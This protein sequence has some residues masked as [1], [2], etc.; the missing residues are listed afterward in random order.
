MSPP[1][2]GNSADT[3]HAFQHSP[4]NLHAKELRLFRLQ[5]TPTGSAQMQGEIQHFNMKEAPAFKALSYVWGPPS[6]LEILINGRTFSVRENLHAFLNEIRSTSVPDQE[7]WFWID[8][9]CIDQSNTLER[10][11][12]VG[13][14]ADIYSSAS[15]TI[16]WLGVSATH[17]AP[18]LVPA[19]NDS[20][21]LQASNSRKLLVSKHAF[22]QLLNCQYWFRTWIIQEFLLATEVNIYWGK[23]RLS[24]NELESLLSSENQVLQRHCQ[25]PSLRPKFEHISNLMNLRKSSDRK[26][27]RW[28]DVL[29]L[30]Q[31]TKCEDTRDRIYAVL[32][33]V[34][35]V[36]AIQ[37]DYFAPPQQ[38]LA[39]VTAANI[40]ADR[41][42]EPGVFCESF[43][44]ARAKVCSVLGLADKIALGPD[45]SRLLLDRFW[46]DQNEQ[47]SL[48][49][50]GQEVKKSMIQ[51]KLSR[52][53]S[54]DP[55]SVQIP[56]WYLRY[57]CA[58]MLL[59]ELTGTVGHYEEQG[60]GPGKELWTFLRNNAYGTMNTESWRD[61]APM[62]VEFFEKR[63]K[64]K[65]FEFGADISDRS[66][67]GGGANESPY[68]NKDTFLS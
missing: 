14:M 63:A 35:P 58:A 64:E 40:G 47:Q 26:A 55:D 42:E 57:E 31:R 28:A 68:S 10:N 56:R 37:A 30:L 66:G 20:G 48:L 4:L 16:V 41:Y 62:I 59:C 32:G 46:N 25:Y 53:I 29:R 65:R 51:L 49:Q 23:I 34:H 7:I 33:L 44:T 21:E 12:Q 2:D 18:P 27:F 36:F 45:V 9:L 39:R 22:V 24:L 8:Q 43:E 60:G 67:Y 52:W 61:R 6:T 38:I 1:I 13:Q 3:Q 11:H 50:G 17:I 54:S 5:S 15:V 19:Q